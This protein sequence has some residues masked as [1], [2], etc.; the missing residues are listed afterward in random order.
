MDDLLS[1]FHMETRTADQIEKRLLLQTDFSI[2]DSIIVQMREKMK[3][4]LLKISRG[5]GNA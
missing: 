1:L 5:E 2:S 4:Y 3:N